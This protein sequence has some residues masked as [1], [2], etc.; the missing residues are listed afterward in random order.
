MALTFEP[1]SHEY[2]LDGSR[3]PSNTQ[4]LRAQGLIRLD[5]IPE[6]VIERARSRGSAVHQLVHYRNEN[7]LDPASIAPEYAPYLAAWDRCAA[8][9]RIIPLLCEHRVGS[10]KH[11]IAGTLDLLC[12]I[13]GEGWLLDYCTGTLEKL[14]KHLQTA[15]YLGMAFEWARE[16]DPALAAVLARHARWRR[17]AIRLRADG[18]YRFIEYTDPTDYSRFV[19]LAA[20]YHIRITEGARL[21]PEDLAA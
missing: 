12:E 16:D 15:G 17:A 13:E 5:G 8:E 6:F 14:A 7:D 20:A 3:T 10:R 19:T 1:A 21:T 11:R 4:V 9:R 2:H 18:T